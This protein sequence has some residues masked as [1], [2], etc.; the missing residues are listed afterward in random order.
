MFLTAYPERG[1]ARRAGEAGAGAMAYLLKPV[2]GAH[3]RS[4][5]EVALARFKELDAVRR[6]VGDLKETS[7]TRKLV[8]QA[9]GVLMKRLQLSEGEAFRRMQQKSRSKDEPSGDCLDDR[10]NRGAP[11]SFGDI[12]NSLTVGE[13]FDIDLS[14]QSPERSRGSKGA[15]LDK[16]H[17]A[18]RRIRFLP[19][20]FLFSRRERR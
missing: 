6:Q 8:E 20:A 10:K 14:P 1:F 15:P 7:E 17:D 3:L 12:R 5:M 9:T 13:G 18:S 19:E 16:G 11:H 2:N 4:A